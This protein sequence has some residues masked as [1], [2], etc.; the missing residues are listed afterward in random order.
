MQVD[1]LMAYVL[2]SMVIVAIPGPNIMLI[3][4]DSVRFGFKQSVM[5]ILG[6]KAGIALLF[7]L[8]LTGL[9]A[10]MALFAPLFAIIK[11]IGVG[12]LIYLGITQLTSSFRLET[13]LAK[14]VIKSKNFFLKGFLVSVT[15]PKGWLFAGAFFPQFINPQLAIGPQIVILCGGFILLSTAIELVYAYAGDTTSRIFS[16]GLFQKMVTRVSGFLLI[17]F[18]IGFAFVK[19]EH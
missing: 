4:N 17:M 15:N 12:Y 2:A 10:L 14:P 3:I 5:T 11:W 18:G 13:T 16:Q 1:T 8:S 9:S 7:F 6:I 19:G